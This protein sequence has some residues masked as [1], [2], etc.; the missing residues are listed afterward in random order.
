MH[1]VKQKMQQGA[2][3][4]SAL[5]ICALAALL[6]THMA[7]RQSMLIHKVMNTSSQQQLL[8]DYGSMQSW[9]ISNLEDLSSKQVSIARGGHYVD[10]SNCVTQ[11]VGGLG[12]DGEYQ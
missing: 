2:A 5:F 6:A 3:L 12:Y 4:I 8:N 11:T 9:A 7:Y 1:K 10:P